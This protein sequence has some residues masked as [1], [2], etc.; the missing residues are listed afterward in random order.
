MRLE[1]K[2]ALVTG[3]GRGIG[4]GIALRLADD[5]ADVIINY[6]RSAKQAEDLVREIEKKGRKAW[7]VQAD[8]SDLDQ[9]AK[10]FDEIKSIS[11]RLDIL[12]NNAGRGAGGMPTL[13]ST[14]PQ[15]YDDMFSLNTK[16][17]FF[18]TQ[19][20]VGMIPDGGRIINIGS[21]AGQA[22]MAGLSV[23]AASKLAIDAFTR[24]WSIELAPRKIT[25]NSILPGIVDTDLIRDNLPKELQKA[26]AAS[27]PLGRMAHP[28]DIAD[29]TAFLASDD[30]R[31]ITGQDIVAAG[32]AA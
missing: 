6:S 13:E 1:G 26:S 10:M 24:C 18:V 2:F 3:A 28:E 7:A 11:S 9:I 14:T 29:I 30:A 22:R 21:T 25:V 23:Y 5:G 27:V 20:S 32:G 19:Q 12:V 16:A 8:I 4:K 31:W 17:L 15:E